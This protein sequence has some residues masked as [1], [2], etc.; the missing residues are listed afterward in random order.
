M[1]RDEPMLRPLAPVFY[2]CYPSF[3]VEGSRGLCLNV[4]CLVP[5][6]VF[7]CFALAFSFIFPFSFHI[8]HFHCQI[9]DHV[10]FSRNSEAERYTHVGQL[11]LVLLFSLHVARSVLLDWELLYNYS[12]HVYGCEKPR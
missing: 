10:V 7:S 12:L 9:I 8:S 4:W 11:T 3:A 1:L 5:N 2:L 6:I